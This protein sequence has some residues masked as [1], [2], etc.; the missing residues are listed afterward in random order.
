MLHTQI[1]NKCKS[2][3]ELILHLA[4]G[5][6][7]FLK[8]N[9]KIILAKK[10]DS[11]RSLV[12][13]SIEEISRLINRNVGK[14]VSWNGEENLRMAELAL[15][16]CN[17]L[18]IHIILNSDEE[19]PELLRQI[20]DP[21]YLL[22]C[23]GKVETLSCLSE[24][25]SVSIVGTR[26]ITPFGKSAARTFAYEAAL[27]GCTVISGLANGVD[28][29]AHEGVVD[30][31]YDTLE[32]GGDISALG[33]TIAVLP[34][35]IDEIVPYSHKRLA[36]K[37]IE[38]GGCLISEYEPKSPI[39]KWQFVGRNRIIA[40]LSP[41]TVVIEAPAGSGALITADFAL[42][43]GRDVMFHEAILKDAAKQISLASKKRLES[44]FAVGRVS[45][46]KVENTTEKYLDA[47]APIIKNYKDY[48]DCLS[49]APGVRTQT[50]V[51]G[52]LFP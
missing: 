46:Y 10:L 13:L 17:T 52:E 50:Y 45:K 35:A 4:L 28:G 8:F 1:N 16:Y 43:N 40:G 29:V 39:G 27:A 37:I 22:F 15:H 31:Y 14:R 48:C 24:R 21:P 12:L 49:E 42:E 6:I 23:R 33:R 44:E 47:G 25:E 20:E 41:A 34:C 5:R 30:A 38:T 2:E 9:E 7:T 11:P 26:R 51:Q 32:K 3:N 36:G 19:Y 18:G